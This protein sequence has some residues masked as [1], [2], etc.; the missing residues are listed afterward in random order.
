MHEPLLTPILHNEDTTLIDQINVE[1]DPE[2]D[3]GNPVPDLGGAQ[4]GKEIPQS[5]KEFHVYARK[6]HKKTRNQFIIS[7][8]SQP[9]IPKDGPAEIPQE[10]PGNTEIPTS[11]TDLPI[12]PAKPSTNHP[13]SKYVSYQNLSQNHQAFTCKI[14][15]LFVPRNIEEA[16]DDPNW[17]LAILEEQDALKKNGAWENV[18]LP[19]DKKASRV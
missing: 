13:I 12:K 19:H 9:E 1:T 15:N 18:S 14:T 6:Y 10:L 16:L 2:I 3:K 8:S 11:N 4:T 7:A 17:K 5:K